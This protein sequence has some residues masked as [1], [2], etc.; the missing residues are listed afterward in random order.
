MRSGAPRPICPDW[1]GVGMQWI[2]SGTISGMLRPKGRRDLLFVTPVWDAVGLS[3]LPGV[4]LGCV[5]LR[6]VQTTLDG[7][8]I[9]PPNN[10]MVPPPAIASVASGA[11]ASGAASA[12]AASGAAT[13]GAASRATMCST[14]TCR[15]AGHAPC[16]ATTRTVTLKRGQ[17][18]APPRGLHT[19][20]ASSS[21]IA[22]RRSQRAPT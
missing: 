14:A 13:T 8:V 19:L 11:A 17:W 15:R 10:V 18:A 4:R 20:K 22:S 6:G 5:C 2:A 12:A 9:T 1:K 3:F 21:C 16:R 7:G